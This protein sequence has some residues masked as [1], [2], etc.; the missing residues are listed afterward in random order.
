MTAGRR[1]A[2]LKGRLARRVALGLRGRPRRDGFFAH[3]ALREGDAGNPPVRGANF[4]LMDQQLALR[5]VRDKHR[6]LR[7]GPG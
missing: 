6:L 7:R 1:R 4:G 5:W 2:S 3:P